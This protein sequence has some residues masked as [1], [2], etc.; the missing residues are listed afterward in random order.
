[1]S[2]K[3]DFLPYNYDLN[4]S[5]YNFDEFMYKYV[6]EKDSFSICLLNMSNLGLC[7]YILGYKYGNVL[8]HNIVNR[9]KRLINQKSYIY[10]FGGNILLI[11]VPN[12]K[13]RRSSVEIVERIMEISD[14]SFLLADKKLK[15]EIKL[16]ISLYPYDDRKLGN[17]FKYAS[18]A[19]NCANKERGSTYEFFNV[20]MY[21]NNAMEEKIRTDIQDALI[22]HEFILYYQ[23][24]VNVN[25]GEIYGVEALI[26]WNH[27][28]FGILTPSY[29]ID[30]IERNGEIKKVGRIV[31]YM[32]CL[33][34]KRLHSLGYSDLIMSVNLSIRQFEDDFFIT[35]I[36]NILEI[37]QVKPEYINFEITERTAINSTEK[38]TSALRNIKDM[39]IKIFVDDFGTQYSFLNYLYS[40]PID[41]IKIDRSFI[42]G[43]DKSEKKFTIVRHLINLANDL[44]LEV[45]AEGMET[46]Q[47]LKCLE[48]ANCINV[49]GFFFGKPLSSNDLVNFMKTSN[50]SKPGNS[51][52]SESKK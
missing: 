21:E 41:G 6:Q 40:V 36:K 47:Q 43:I 15:L 45:V 11:I 12:I 10:K 2:M 31:F 16:G 49:Q 42:N 46:E 30:G 50:F 34:A 8:L 35:F 39:G 3:K 19:L 23:P 38:I 32:A 51:I 48:K 24:Q 17:V 14:D 29:F 37:T 18:I 22:N 4:Y 1:M 20:N 27:P 5:I 44:N 13:S 26:R 9:I 52:F 33:E 25:S 28:E 7:N